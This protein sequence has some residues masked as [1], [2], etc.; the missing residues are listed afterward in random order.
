MNLELMEFQ[1]KAAGR[2]LAHLHT[3]RGEATPRTPQAVSPATRG[4]P[5]AVSLSSPTGSGKTVIATYVIEVLLEGNELHAG[6]PDATFLWL[7]DQVELNLQTRNKMIATSTVLDKPKLLVIDAD[8][9]QPELTAGRVYFLNTQKLGRNSGLTKKVDGQNHTIWETIQNTME[10]RPGSFYV[11][12]DEA[13]RGM[14]PGRD[15]EEANSIIQKFLKGAAGQISPAPIVLAISATLKRFHEVMRDAQH[16]QRLVDVPIEEVRRSGLLKDTVNLFYPDKGRSADLTLLRQAARALN[17]YRERWAR[18]ASDTAE[19]LVR[20]VLLVQVQDGRD[21]VLTRTN[22]SQAIKALQDE[23][24]GISPDGFAHAFQEQGPQEVGGMTLRYLAPAAIDADPDVEVVFFKTSLNLGWDCP[25]A[26]VM[27]SFRSATD[28]TSI[29]Q[30]VGRMVRAPL[31]RK[32]ERDEQLNT[33]ALYLPHYDRKTLQKVIKSLRA[34]GS[35]TDV[36]EGREVALLERRADSDELFAQLGQLP[37]YLIPRK[38]FSSQARRL[39]KLAALLAR[40]DIDAEAPDTAR[41]ALG[42]ALVKAY[43]EQREEAAFTEIVKDSGTIEVRRV[44]WQYSPES[45]PEE[46]IQLEISPENV[47]DLFA[48]A[49]RRFG[50]GLHLAYWKARAAEGVIDHQRTKLEAYALATI[51]LVVEELEDVAQAEVARLFQKHDPQIREL[52][53]APRLAFEE[54]RGLAIEPTLTHPAYPV[55]IE[56]VKVER[57]WDD[58]LYV[59]G[60]GKLSF[61]PTTWET[62]TLEE[63]LAREDSVGWLRNLDKKPWSICVPYWMDGAWHGCYPDFLFLRR[64]EGNLIVDIVDPHLLSQEDAWSKAVGLAQYAARHASAFGRIELVRLR[65]GV[66]DRLDLCDEKIRAQVLKVSSNPHLRA[67]FDQA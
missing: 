4:M 54:I 57:E 8:F 30:L 21:K 38:A 46:M 7:T 66:L 52:P 51:D 20:P 24:P 26:E 58:H 63:E 25:R 33:V 44:Q 1:E 10:A 67:L 23:I 42:A 22:L 28:P 3:G 47:A 53:E 27:M 64:S 65:K 60:Q 19:A 34:D 45:L 32:V 35:A 13:H 16:V 29:A 40:T 39:G 15:R 2:L 37:T 9:D 17:D 55:T 43:T 12:I 49:G 59:D 56:M 11:I 18:Y 6:D 61:K 62:A 48:W 31:A 41:A 50:E 36:R 14:H 5:Q